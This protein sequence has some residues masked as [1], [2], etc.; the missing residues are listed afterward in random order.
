MSC[1]G[2]HRHP[3]SHGSRCWVRG[4][5]TLERNTINTMELLL[6]AIKMCDTSRLSPSC[7]LLELCPVHSFLSHLPRPVSRFIRD[8]HSIIAKILL[9]QSIMRLDVMR[10]RDGY[11]PI[12]HGVTPPCQYPDSDS[13]TY[14]PAILVMLTSFVMAIFTCLPD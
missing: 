5:A 9:Q 4:G 2:A 13:G 7:A 12:C 10:R 11:R 8:V 6:H 1:T 14:A 3:A